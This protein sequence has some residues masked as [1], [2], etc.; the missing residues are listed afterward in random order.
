M[1]KQSTVIKRMIKDGW[2]PMATI[3]SVVGAI[4]G[5]SFL[6][7]AVLGWDP[8][9]TYWGLILAWFIGTAVKWLYEMKRDEIA[10]EHK[11]LLRDIERKHL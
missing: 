7:E 5:A 10:Y 9:T 11:E 1:I 2:K 8:N 6:A 3:V 4:F